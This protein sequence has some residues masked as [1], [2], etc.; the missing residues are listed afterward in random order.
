[1]SYHHEKECKACGGIYSSKVITE[2]EFKE[3]TDGDLDEQGIEVSYHNDVSVVTT[4]GCCTPCHDDY[5][6]EGEQ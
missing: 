5:E 1:M 2:E 3:M 6:N 4:K